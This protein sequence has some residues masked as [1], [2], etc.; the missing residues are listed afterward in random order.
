ME[1]NDSP[2]GK[3]GEK[4]SDRGKD[5]KKKNTPENLFIVRRVQS[6]ALRKSKR[7]EEV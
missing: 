3:D 4:R 6:V 5:S 1:S 2:V 7:E